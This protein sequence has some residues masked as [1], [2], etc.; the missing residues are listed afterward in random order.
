[1]CR[2]SVRQYRRWAA[3]AERRD[4]PGRR[5]DGGGAARGDG[6]GGHAGGAAD[7]G[8]GRL[9]RAADKAQIPLNAMTRDLDAARGQLQAVLDRIQQTA[10]QAAVES[11]EAHEISQAIA[12]GTSDLSARRCRPWRRRSAAAVFLGLCWCMCC[13]LMDSTLHSGEEVRHA[14]RRAVPRVDPGGGQARAGAPED[15]RLCRAPA[16]DRVRRT[17][18]VVARRRVAGYRPSADHHRHRR[19]PGRRQIA[20]DPGAGP[21]GAAW[22]RARP[23]DR[24]RSAPGVFQHRLGGSASPGLDGGAARRDSNGARRCRTIR[25]PA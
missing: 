8:Q 1:M 6:S 17:G 5:G 20:A 15:P 10:Q 21:L 18:P 25:S 12:A 24:M 23:G 4:R 13:R 22:W 19:P 14:D 9:R 3:G 7:A 2:A 16:A 11:S